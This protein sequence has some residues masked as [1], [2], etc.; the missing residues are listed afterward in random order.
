MELKHITVLLDETVENLNVKPE[1]TYVDCTLG[2]G[3]HS[4]EIV[5]ALGSGGQLIGI[6]QDEI[7]LETA[8]KR[9]EPYLDKVTL[10]RDNFK[11]VKKALYYRDFEEIDGIIFD[12]GFSSLQ[13]DDEERGFSYQADA[14]LDMRMDQRQQLTA[15]EIVNS[16]SE[17]EIYRII[18]EYGEDKW[19]S[20]IAQFIVRERQKKSL[21]TTQELVDIIKAAIPA[22]ARR[23]G[24]HPAKRTFQAL[25]IAVND[26]LGVLKKALQ[27]CIDLLKPGGRIC[28]ISFHSLEDRM[29]KQFFRDLAKDC[30]CPKNL[31][32][33]VCNI[34]P[35]LKVITRKP[36]TPSKEELE[37][38][39]RARSAILRVAE[40]L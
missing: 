13:V 20:R 6:D 16:W 21:Q 5:K 38:N 19:A 15:K 31:P 29:V 36:I 8:K 39:P 26:E 22:S 18:N 33:C 35:I 11:N 30:I 25:R 10:V 34:K 2:G 7:A 1:G 3:G 4:F 9:L 40:K 37:K 12:L 27:D 23:K 32:V 17:K 14:E 24:S 28:I